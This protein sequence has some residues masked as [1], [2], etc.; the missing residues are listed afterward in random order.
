MAVILLKR[1]LNLKTAS[2]SL[3]TVVVRMKYFVRSK[4]KYYGY[5]LILK[6]L[7]QLPSEFT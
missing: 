3:Q 2:V 5:N 7:C 1:R 6:L 4:Q